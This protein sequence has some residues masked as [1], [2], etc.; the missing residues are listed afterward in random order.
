[1]SILTVVANIAAMLLAY[2]KP[3]PDR[4]PDHES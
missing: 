2:D 1:M 3:K 4:T